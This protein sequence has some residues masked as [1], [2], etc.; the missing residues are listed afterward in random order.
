[1]EKK[2]RIRE[3]DIFYQLANYTATLAAGS[4]LLNERTYNHLNESLSKEWEYI[5]KYFEI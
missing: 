5:K 3:V 4:V 1:M 2:D